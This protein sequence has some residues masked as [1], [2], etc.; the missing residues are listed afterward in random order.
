MPEASARAALEAG[1]LETLLAA[2][3]LE[4]RGDGVAGV[5]TLV[6]FGPLW[7]AIDQPEKVNTGQGPDL[8]MGL[9]RQQPR[10]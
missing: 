8:V 2:G 1:P 10:T 4:R 3:V 5:V 6:P 7:L 9:E